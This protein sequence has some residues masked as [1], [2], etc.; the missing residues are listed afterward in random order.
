MT[1]GHPGLRI[2]EDRWVLNR[3]RAGPLTR[4]RVDAMVLS[5]YLVMLPHVDMDGL[6]HYSIVG[7]IEERA[8]GDRLWMASKAWEAYPCAS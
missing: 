1:A 7:G 8:R 4:A 6:E 2:Y 3:E 5:G